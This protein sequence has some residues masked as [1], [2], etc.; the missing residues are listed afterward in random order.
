PDSRDPVRVHAHRPRP[1]AASSL[2][3]R[4]QTARYGKTGW[5]LRPMLARRSDQAPPTA[6]AL[7]ALADSAEDQKTASARARKVRKPLRFWAAAKRFSPK[8]KRP[9]QAQVFL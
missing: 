9:T 7:L 1:I 3:R 2:L 5:K 6:R 8:P 4:L